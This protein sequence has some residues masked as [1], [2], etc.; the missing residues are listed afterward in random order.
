MLSVRYSPAVE[1]RCL[2]CRPYYSPNSGSPFCGE[3]VMAITI[4]AVYENGVLKPCEPLPLKDGDKVRIAVSS[5]E[6]PILKAYGI[7]GWTGDTQTLERIALDPEFLPEES[8]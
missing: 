8:S 4:E 2:G 7:M 6:S 3:Q 1:L 5:L